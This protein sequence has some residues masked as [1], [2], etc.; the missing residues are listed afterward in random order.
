MGLVA[1]MRSQVGAGRVA[2]PGGLVD[3]VEDDEPR[4]DDESN[5][6]ARKAHI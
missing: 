1:Y 5:P 3:V 2:R 6:G 4:S